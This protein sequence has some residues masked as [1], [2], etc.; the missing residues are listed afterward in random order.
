MMEDVEAG[1][2]AVPVGD[3]EPAAVILTFYW[4]DIWGSSTRQNF[5]C[6]PSTT[7]TNAAVA[8]LYPSVPDQLVL[9]DTEALGGGE[10]IVD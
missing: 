6:S 10:E 8:R 1:R 3:P 2:Y 9:P 4:E 7:A 5:Y